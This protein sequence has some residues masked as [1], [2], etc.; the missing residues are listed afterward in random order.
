MNIYKNWVT[1]SIL[2]PLSQMSWGILQV[3]L[4]FRKNQNTWH[5]I[6]QDGIF[7]CHCHEN[8]K[9]HKQ[10]LLS[11]FGFCLLPL[12][13]QTSGSLKVKPGAQTTAVINLK[14][15]H[16][17]VLGEVCWPEIEVSYKHCTTQIHIGALFWT[18]L[19]GRN[20]T[21]S[22]IQQNKMSITLSLLSRIIFNSTQKKISRPTT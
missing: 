18:G 3:K 16:L 11:Y 17:S 22:T 2:C 21:T 14:S 6:P 5:L 19:W 7:H 4:C 13:L 15:Q 1:G 10:E 9:S 8:L 20:F 12:M